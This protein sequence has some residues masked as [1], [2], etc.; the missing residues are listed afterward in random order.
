MAMPLSFRITSRLAL[1]PPALLSASIAMPEA[2][3]ASPITAIWW[4]LFSFLIL[5]AIAIPRA[6][7][8]DVEECPVPKSS[9]SLSDIFGKPLIPS[10]VRFFLNA[11]RLPVRILCA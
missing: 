3:E 4:R 6:A 8:M 11:S 2:M 9:Y 7:D 10:M 1:A 5:D